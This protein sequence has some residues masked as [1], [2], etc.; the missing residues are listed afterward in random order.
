MGRLLLLIRTGIGGS[1]LFDLLF[2]T[3]SWCFTKM[4]VVDYVNIK[5]AC[6]WKYSAYML[7]HVSVCQSDPEAFTGAKKVEITPVL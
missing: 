4:T 7:V 1:C 6:F 3:D 2:T 5:N